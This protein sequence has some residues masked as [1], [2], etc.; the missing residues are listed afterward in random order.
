MNDRKSVADYY[1]QLIDER[2]RQIENNPEQAE[3]RHRTLMKHVT[4][5]KHLRA[6][7]PD[8]CWEDV[9][10]EWLYAM[11]CH[12]I[13]KG[14]SNSYVK[15]LLRDVKAFLNWAYN[16]GY[17]SN[18][19]FRSY[20][21]KCR[22]ETCK[23][24]SGNKFALSLEELKILQDL[25][26][27]K[28]GKLQRTRDMFLFCCY[29]GLRFSDAMKLRWCDIGR[30]S[31]K[32]VTQKTNQLLEIP[33]TKQMRRILE[34]YNKGEDSGMVFPRT[35]NMSYNTQLQTVGRI[36]GFDEDWVKVRQCGNNIT[37]IHMKKYQCLSSHVA[38]RTFST[39]ALQQG[40]PTE[41]IM[42]ITGH[43]TAKMLQGYMK[44][45]P[46]MKRKYMERFAID[47]D[48]ESLAHQIMQL[49]EDKMAQLFTMIFSSRKA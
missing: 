29:T 28:H 6:F 31:I 40:M 14:Y 1:L 33:I 21:V 13:A 47:T 17:S 7:A 8:A 24:I 38:R 43:T 46:G 32:I 25:D 42:S 35:T 19:S 12:L 49:P 4:A 26:L 37:T 27:R 36:A 34:C 45:N 48:L 16:M 10:Q 3:W 30:N 11:E 15:R 23:M 41:V 39:I 44:I 5:Q 22:D 20:H 2:R 18:T 9:S